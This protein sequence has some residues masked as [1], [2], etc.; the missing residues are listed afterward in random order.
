MTLWTY[1]LTVLVTAYQLLWQYRL[2]ELLMTFHFRLPFRSLLILSR[3]K[4]SAFGTL[5]SELRTLGY[6][7]AR[8]S[9]SIPMSQSLFSQ[10]FDHTFM[11]QVYATTGTLVVHD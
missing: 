3:V 8:L 7:V 2:N 1:L 6:P 5:S 4:L 11:Y 9:R 10:H